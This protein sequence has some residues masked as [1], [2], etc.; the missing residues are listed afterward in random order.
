MGDRVSIQFA[1]GDERS[2]VLFSHWGGV[3]FVEMANNYADELCREM[4]WKGAYPLERLE[5]SIVMVYFIR[6]LSKKGIIPHSSRVKSNYYLGAS[7][8]DGDNGDNGHHTIQLENRL[9]NQIAWS[10]L[11][12][13]E[14]IGKL[15]AFLTKNP[16]YEE[17]LDIV[18]QDDKR[19]KEEKLDT[20][21]VAKQIFSTLQK[22]RGV[23][24]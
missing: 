20:E 16:I 12:S 8:D 13:Q 4:D 14:Q 15:T 10:K 2:V 24:Q 3:N 11:L 19:I 7:E 17:V 21:T 5:P 22:M 18:M 1:K 9:A 23:L 6:W